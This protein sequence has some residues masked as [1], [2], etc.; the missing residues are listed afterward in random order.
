MASINSIDGQLC[1]PDLLLAV[2]TVQSPR[3]RF[4]QPAKSQ[5]AVTIVSKSG[6]WCGDLES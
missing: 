3:R 6:D 1:T 4:W 2:V 5:A